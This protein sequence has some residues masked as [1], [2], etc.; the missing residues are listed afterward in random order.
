[1]NLENRPGNRLSGPLVSM[2]TIN[3][4]YILYAKGTNDNKKVRIK[5]IMWC[6]RCPLASVLRIG[7]LLSLIHI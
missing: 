5:K 1:M 4:S 3:F 6:N 7:Y 2:G